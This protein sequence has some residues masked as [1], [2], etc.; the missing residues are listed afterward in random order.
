M[1]TELRPR[2]LGAGSRPT[3]GADR[4]LRPATP[5]LTGVRQ[6]GA[7]SPICPSRWLAGYELTTLVP[8]Q[9]LGGPMDQSFPQRDSGNKP[10]RTE[11]QRRIDQGEHRETILEELYRGI[12][13]QLYRR[14][15]AS[16]RDAGLA[17]DLV[18]TVFMKMYDSFDRMITRE[19]VLPWILKVANNELID[20][21]RK[22]KG[23]GELLAEFEIIEH[24]L[25]VKSWTNRF[26]EKVDTWVSIIEPLLIYMQA[27]TA[28]G[29][30]RDTDL[31]AYW[32]G[33]VAGVTQRELAD[34]S[35]LTQGRISQLKSEV[36]HQVRA[37]LYVCEILGLVRPPHREAEI[38]THLDLLEMASGVTAED[39]ALLRLAGGAVRLD[40]LY[41]P[42]LLPEDAEAAIKSKASRVITL[43]ELHETESRYAAA[44]PNPTPR[45]IESPCAAHS[46]S[47]LEPKANDDE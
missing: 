30:L 28:K 17:E 14:A 8:G 31:D 3:A 19:P 4:L 44:I 6:T 45:C 15:Y 21:Y 1:Q 11:L 37:A 47:R 25:A 27:I 26:E 43:H 13:T 16:L 12:Q 34:R 10:P 41:V 40:P 18:Q 23:D 7:P 46:A 2:P 42:V 39:R 36:Q 35:G 38:R 9:Y 5:A 24:S 33:A 20:R 32:Q 29:W 22:T